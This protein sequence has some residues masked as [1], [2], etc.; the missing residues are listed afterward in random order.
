LGYKY[1]ESQEA[2]YISLSVLRAQAFNSSW[3]RPDELAATCCC[4]D[5]RN[6]VKIIFRSQ[7]RGRTVGDFPAENS[8]LVTMAEGNHAY[9]SRTRPLSLP[10]PM[11]RGPRGPGRVGRCQ[12]GSRKA[13]QHEYQG[14]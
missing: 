10:A 9:P 3:Q 13:V 5:D 6:H 11:V 12:A 2:Y 4:E 8:G 7:E 14:L 1:G